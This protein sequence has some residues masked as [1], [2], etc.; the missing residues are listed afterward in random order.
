MNRMQILIATIFCFLVSFTFTTVFYNQVEASDY[1]I[2]K[3]ND[4]NEAYLVTDTI[5]ETLMSHN[6]YF[7]GYKY[8]CKVKSVFPDSREYYYIDYTFFCNQGIPY[9][10]KDNIEYRKRSE[11]DYPVEFALRSYFYKFSQERHPNQWR[12]E[13]VLSR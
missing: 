2:G 7:D 10:I 3:Y 8:D 12:S 6:G 4:G 5:Y 1:Y 13:K 11:S 9:W